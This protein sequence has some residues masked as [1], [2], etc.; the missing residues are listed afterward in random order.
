MEQSYG[1]TCIWQMECTRTFQRARLTAAVSVFV[2]PRSYSQACLSVSPLDSPSPEP[3]PP[4]IVED[5]AGTGA[6]PGRPAIGRA[7]RKARFLFRRA[8][9]RHSNLIA[10][11]FNNL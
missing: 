5:I 4:D 1:L 3:D 8:G 10:S 6:T 2:R 7:R 9:R 11:P